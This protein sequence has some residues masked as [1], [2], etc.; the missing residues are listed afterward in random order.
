MRRRAHIHA[1]AQTELR[2]PERGDKDERANHGPLLAGKEPADLEVAQIMGDGVD[3]LR[4]HDVSPGALALIASGWT[5]WPGISPSAALTIRWRSTRLLPA[6]F[7]LSIATVKCDSPL[8]S[9]PAW[10]W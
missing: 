4:D 3:C 9:S 10:P 7:A 5:R 1:R 8:P 2:R 6:N